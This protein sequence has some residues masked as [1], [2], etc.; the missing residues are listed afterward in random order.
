MC[1]KNW[2]TFLVFISLNI[3][4]VMGADSYAFYEKSEIKNFLEK[5]DE[6]SFIE[7]KGQWDQDVLYLCRMN[8][9]DIWITRKGINYTF[10]KKDKIGDGRCPDHQYDVL[11]GHR[12]IIEWEGC[13]SD[14]IVQNNRKDLSYHN[15]F[16]NG[17]RNEGVS[18]VPLYKEVLIKNLYEKIDIR[19]YFD[20]GCL[21]YDFI[22]Y[23]GGDPSN[24]KFKIRGQYNDVVKS[25]EIVCTT[26]FGEMS[27]S[28]LYSYQNNYWRVESSFVKQENNTYAIEIGNYAK[29]Q[30][31]VIDPLIYSTY[32]GGSIDDNSYSIAVNNTGEVYVAGKTS[33]VNY[34]VTPGVF[35]IFNNGADDVFVTKLNSSGNSLVFSTYIGGTSGETANAIDIDALGDIYITG[36]TISNN[37]PTTSGVFQSTHGGGITDAF[38]TKLNSTGSSLVYSTYIGGNASD[39]GE[40]IFVDNGGNAYITGYTASS[41][42]DVTPGSYQTINDGFNDIFI[43]KLNPGG[44][45]LIYSTYLGGSSNDYGLGI[46]VDNSGNAYIT[47]RTSS[48]N[49][50]ITLGAYQVVNNGMDDA[51]I[52][53]INSSGTS[54]IYSTYIGGSGND[55]GRDITIDNLGNAY[56]TGKTTSI[57]FD[58][59]AGAFQAILQGS[60]DAFVSKIDLSAG[61]LVYSTYIGGSGI[62]DGWGIEIDNFSN[63]VIV[64][65]TNSIDFD[66][67]PNATQI[68]NNGNND[69]FLSVLDLSIN[70]LLY[71]TYLG[72]S[73]NDWG[74]D[75]IIDCENNTY[76]TGITTSGDYVVTTGSYQTSPDGSYE[77][78]ITKISYDTSFIILLSP[79]FADSQ[80][81]CVNEPIAPIVYSI[82]LGSNI[83]V[84]GLPNGVNSTISISGDSI[85]IIGVPISPGIFNYTITVIVGC[86]NVTATGLIIVNQSP[87]INVI[88]ANPDICMGD[89]IL[90]VAEGATN[91][92]WS[93][94]I[95][96]SATNQDSVIAFPSTN[97]TY[98]VIGIDSNNCSDSVNVFI[99]VHNPPQV[100]AYSNSPVCEGDTLNL[101]SQPNG[102]NSYSW[103]GPNGY[104]ST[105]QNPVISNVSMGSGG[106]YTVTVVDGN[107]CEGMGVV[108]VVISSPPTASISGDLEICEG[109]STV[110]TAG[111]GGPYEWL[112]NGSNS[113]SVV[114]SPVQTT[115]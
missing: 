10:Y 25:N 8:G 73:S 26:R 51:I 23:P 92:I 2:N 7:N 42:F 54:L 104:I 88:P 77:S 11:F 49:Y 67:T 48:N 1:W 94:S 99:V 66:I 3:Y 29:D 22:V 36:M 32:L 9:T 27:V 79:S 34:D 50:D 114:V 38:I 24:I 95:G 108:N 19:Y 55:W 5:K 53:K 111:G 76:I 93:P 4:Q 100:Q 65:Y 83:N 63:V 80:I 35:Q 64:G 103:S 57:D 41:N 110:L 97:A 52:T 75:L 62:D 58:V 78:F 6:L 106:T 102:M 39:W 45:G 20:K 17:W 13:N 61:T 59:T 74:Y 16:I 30:L 43:S 107:G 33:S 96:L 91:Y 71:S 21:R 85:I 89:S 84:S 98:T 112:H 46:V 44:S 109:E 70:N 72:G 37:Y 81:V 18:Y 68:T 101:F 69:V 56:V 28:D 14:I 105:Q 90:L 113:Q 86:I 115:S 82:P 60:D 12:I 31:L 87:S 40:G 15:Y 47:G